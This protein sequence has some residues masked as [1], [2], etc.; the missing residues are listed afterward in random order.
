MP[1][2]RRVSDVK[3]C[4][5]SGSYLDSKKPTFPGRPG[6]VGRFNVGESVRGTFDRF[7]GAPHS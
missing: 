7:E 5:G 3:R 2:L 4:A 1:G 6:K